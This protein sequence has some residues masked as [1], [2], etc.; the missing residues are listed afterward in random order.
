MSLTKEESDMIAREIINKIPFFVDKY[1]DNEFYAIIKVNNH[2]EGV[3]V[4]SSAFH[5]YL[6]NM[7]RKESGE[8]FGYNFKWLIQEK[9]DEVRFDSSRKIV[10]YHRMAGN[11]KS[12]T[13]FLANDLNQCIV[14]NRKAWEV[15]DKTKYLF[16]KK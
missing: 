15:A 5:A 3:N 6:R 16:I 7:Y 11:N 9:T 8:N 10:P 2:I 4:F 13:Y 14:I 1:N 12:I